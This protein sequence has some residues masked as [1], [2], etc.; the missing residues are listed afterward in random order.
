[1]TKTYIA[2]NSNKMSLY[3]HR[4]CIINNY[5]SHYP[6]KNTE[7][8]LQTMLVHLEDDISKLEE[9]VQEK[10]HQRRHEIIERDIQPR[11]NNLKKLGNQINGLT[12][13]LEQLIFAF[14]GIALEV[15]QIHN[16]I[17]TK[18]MPE[19]INPSHTCANNLVSINLFS[20][21]IV[22]SYQSGFILKDKKMALHCK[23]NLNL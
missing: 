15:N 4:L 8:T 17:A 21:P 1:M 14:Q 3:Q 11:M 16:Q 18:Q 6:A 13:E 2:Q 22:V 5:Y 19:N 7:E 10:I 20:L 23:K 9:Y 12:G